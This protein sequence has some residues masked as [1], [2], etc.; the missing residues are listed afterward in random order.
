MAKPKDGQ[1][2]KIESLQLVD[3]GGRDAYEGRPEFAPDFLPREVSDVELA[4]N[5]SSRL[6]GADRDAAIL[7]NELEKIRVPKVETNR[8]RGGR[9]EGSDN[10]IQDLDH[11]GL[12][13][14]KVQ[15]ICGHYVEVDLSIDVGMPAVMAVSENVS[16]RV[17]TLRNCTIRD[18]RKGP[19][20]AHD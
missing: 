9:R 17:R 1:T 18:P 11:L 3:A 13:Q 15:G 5:L 16:E 19:S 12:F 4:Q 7:K 6:P 20:M 2:S 8:G 10:F 14:R